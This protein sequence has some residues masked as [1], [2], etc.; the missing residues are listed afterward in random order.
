MVLK[1]THDKLE[2]I[3]E[4]F[5]ELYT[6]KNGRYELTGIAGVK[7]SADVERLQ[8]ALTKERN[9]HKA[10][11]EK[12]HVWDDYD[13]DEIVKKL[14]LLPEL[15]A[16]AKGKLDEAQI[17]EMVE[18]RVKGTINSQLSPL[19]RKIKQLE[20]ENGELK[21]TNEMW[22]GKDRTRKV[23]DAVR[24]QLT[25]QKVLMDAHE[26]ALLLA[27]RV[28]EVREDD[29][30]IV[31]KEGAGVTPGLDPAGWLTEMQDRRRHWWGESVG[32]G[33]VGSGGR[34]GGPLAGK[35]PFSAEHW[36]MTEQGRIYKQHGRDRAEQ[37]AKAAG[38]SLGGPKPAP[39]KQGAGA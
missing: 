12:L 18:R 13:H 33:T 30:A 39:R 34:G 7:T 29:G 27:D 23:H 10:T 36:N 15:E 8:A 17:E 14:D 28:F 22:V 11:K 9:D 24:K 1:D 35:N 31:T 4:Q 37:L 32:G 19:E 38:T 3:P 21:T 2:D 25:E 6:E 16:A 20:K 5:Q 26:D